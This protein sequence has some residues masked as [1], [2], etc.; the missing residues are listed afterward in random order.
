MGVCRTYV[1]HDRFTEFLEL[2]LMRW[3]QAL[4]GRAQRE[5]VFISNEVWGV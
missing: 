4:L 2:A 3:V 1:G 5:K